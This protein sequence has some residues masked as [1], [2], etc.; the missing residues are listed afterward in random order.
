M[1]AAEER[2][3]NEVVAHAESIK[4]I[5]NLRK[6][7]STVQGTA[8]EN[9]T[10]AETAKANLKTS[11]ESWKH[12]KD[13]LDKEVAGLKARYVFSHMLPTN[14]N[15]KRLHRSCEDLS[16]QNAILHQHLESVSSQAARIRQTADAAPSSNEGE[17]GDDAD[18]K[19]S[20]LRSVV[21]YL[22]KEK[23]IV[24]LQLEL[25]KQEN[26]RLKTQIDHLSQNLDETRKTLSEVITWSTWSWS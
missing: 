24:D 1:Q 20:E 8:R 14:I 5:D 18:A 19:L 17:A 2:Y 7:L 6:E 10:L 26:A 21:A 13:A 11:E 12:Q 16:S 9:A 15:I 23:E 4:A 3:S 22:R 25:S